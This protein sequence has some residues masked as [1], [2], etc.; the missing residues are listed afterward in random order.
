[1]QNIFCRPED[2]RK[3]SIYTCPLSKNTKTRR[4][5]FLD[6]SLQFVVRKT[7]AFWPAGILRF[8]CALSCA[9]TCA[10]TKLKLLH[11]AV[12]LSGSEYL[13]FFIRIGGTKRNLH[14]RVVARKALFCSFQN[15]SRIA[16]KPEILESY[17]SQREN[18]GSVPAVH[19]SKGALLW[20]Q[21]VCPVKG[22]A[23]RL[24]CAGTADMCTSYKRD[25]SGLIEFGDGH[26]GLGIFVNNDDDNKTLHHR[27]YRVCCPRDIYTFLTISP[28]GA[29]QRLSLR[30]PDKLISFE[31]ARASRDQCL[32]V[33]PTLCQ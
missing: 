25:F 7:I 5:G 21:Q 26:Y 15:N 32:S 12:S 27:V 9:D 14:K 17:I 10:V 30:N 19:T 33:I 4:C 22:Y 18:S 11:Q 23:S 28:S 31:A 20:S 2:E 16:Q 29:E 3:K 8:A 13:R 24:R 1:M 6:N